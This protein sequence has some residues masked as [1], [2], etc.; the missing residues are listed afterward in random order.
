MEKREKIAS[1][2]VLKN[3]SAVLKNVPSG[4]T[5]C[6]GLNVRALVELDSKRENAAAVVVVRKSVEEIMTK[7]FH[8]TRENALNGR[9][10]RSGIVAVHHAAVEIENERENA[11]SELTVRVLPWKLKLVIQI[12]ARFSKNGQN[13]RNVLLPAGQGTGLAREIVLENFATEKKNKQKNAW[14]LNAHLGRLGLIGRTA[15]LAAE[16]LLKQ[17]SVTA[18]IQP[19]RNHAME[20]H[21]SLKTALS[22]LVL[23]GLNGQ[24]GPLAPF[25]AEAEGVVN[26]ADACTVLDVKEV[27]ATLSKLSFATQTPVRTGQNGQSLILALFHVVVEFR[28]ATDPARVAM[29]VRENQWRP[30][31]ATKF[32]VR[33]GLNILIGLLARL[34][35]AKE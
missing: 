3:L 12:S 15:V 16:I 27:L 22:L 24:N 21:P 26:P 14:K 2:Q 35:A 23:T 5:G 19:L 20:H 34:L 7:R 30:T 4:L 18:C 17:E 9:H 32:L 25:P 31:L 13:G 1:D 10:G 29:I 8:V 11:S 33:N 6:P 28:S